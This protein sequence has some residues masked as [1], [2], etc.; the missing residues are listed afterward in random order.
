MLRSTVPFVFGLALLTASNARAV[1]HSWYPWECCSDNDCAPIALDETPIERD[2]GFYLIDGRHISYR[3]LKPSPDE[4][5]HL[6]E[7]KGPIKVSERKII[8]VYAPHGGS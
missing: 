8:C 2:G 1:A 7:Q 6:C 3:D 5:W 4:H